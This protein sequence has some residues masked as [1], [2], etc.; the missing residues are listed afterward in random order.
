M[1]ILDRQLKQRK[2]LVHQSLRLTPEEVSLLEQRTLASQTTSPSRS[3]RYVFRACAIIGV[4]AVAAI[5][6]W[7]SP[8]TLLPPGT[9]SQLVSPPVTAPDPQQTPAPALP[10]A[11]KQTVAWQTEADKLALYRVF[12]LGMTYDEA[13][14]LFPELGELQPLGGIESLGEDG[15]QEAF[16]PVALGDEQVQLTLSFEHGFLYAARYWV[17]SKDEQ[18][19]MQ[20]KARLEAFYAK[21]FGSPEEETIEAG[22]SSTWSPFFGLGLTKNWDGRYIL[23]WGLQGGE[24]GF[25]ELYR[26]R[27]FTVQ[28]AIELALSEQPEF[29]AHPGETKQVRVEGIPETLA[30]TSLR[31][32][33]K[34]QTRDSYL[35]TF[36][37]MWTIRYDGNRSITIP[38]YWTY[39]VT[40]GEVK[41]VDS[42]VVDQAVME[43][44]RGAASAQSS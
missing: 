19:I 34:L 32:K 44:L 10:E 6:L 4:A 24:P 18:K 40:E 23:I 41:L 16:M 36:E 38:S 28:E 7:A 3:K 2:E 5:L 26:D 30:T 13:K 22:T 27:A 8:L 42:Y 35:V 31:T 15:L 9:P 25:E 20:E 43:Y 17:E 14:A 33:V 39:Q 12:A 37:R 29:P 21:D 11:P 1:D